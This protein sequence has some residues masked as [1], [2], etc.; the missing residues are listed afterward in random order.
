M[1]AKPPILPRHYPDAALLEQ[2]L[3]TLQHVEMISR[4]LDPTLC[5]HNRGEARSA[6]PP[7]LM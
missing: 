1:A 6:A 3:R 2:L 4:S 7:H 5:Q